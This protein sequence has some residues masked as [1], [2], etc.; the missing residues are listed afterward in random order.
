MTLHQ[1][2]LSSS[3]NDNQVNP[4]ELDVLLENQQELEE[5]RRNGREQERHESDRKELK[6]TRS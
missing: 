2:I 4:K 6:G 5:I 1:A 3:T